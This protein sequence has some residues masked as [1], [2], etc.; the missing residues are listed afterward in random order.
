MVQVSSFRLNYRTKNKEQRTKNEEE[1]EEEEETR[2]KKK[3]KEEEEERR[4]RREPQNFVVEQKTFGSQQQRR[5]RHR[6]RHRHRHRRRHHH[7]HH[8]LLPF[9]ALPASPLSFFFFLCS[10]PNSGDGDTIDDGP[11]FLSIH[12]NLAVVR[13]AHALQMSTITPPLSFADL[14]RR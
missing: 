3:K 8:H 2:K 12:R 1:E 9:S 11:F 6:H 13:Y 4:R 10:A 14:R 7:H 5:A